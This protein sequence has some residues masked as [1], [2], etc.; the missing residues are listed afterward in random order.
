MRTPLE[1]SEKSEENGAD[2]FNQALDSNACLVMEDQWVF[3]HK[4]YVMQK[5]GFF[6]QLFLNELNETPADYMLSLPS[7]LRFDN[8]KTIVL[9]MYT[10]STQNITSENGISMMREAKYLLMPDEFLEILRQSFITAYK[11]QEGED[12]EKMAMSLP[13]VASDMSVKELLQ[14]FHDCVIW[15]DLRMKVLTSWIQKKDLISVEELLK[16]LDEC[17]IQG[18]LHLKLLALWLLEH[19]LSQTEEQPSSLRKHLS[20]VLKTCTQA[21]LKALR[22]EH[23]DFFDDLPAT[24]LFDL[25]QSLG[26]FR[27]KCQVC[28]KAFCSPEESK[29]R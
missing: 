28:G 21:G 18:D 22:T 11:A 20:K 4:E 12:Q 8:V 16:L 26:R 19:P 6:D 9:W 17:K 13:E 27:T 1:K 23:P 10:G 29:A 25:T 2:W 7:N 14:L 15:G 3:I 5:S 24:A